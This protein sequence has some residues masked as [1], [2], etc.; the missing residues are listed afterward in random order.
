MAYNAGNLKNV[1]NFT[2]EQC[3]QQ[4]PRTLLAAAAASSSGGGGSGAQCS[5]AD[6]LPLLPP[7]RLAPPAA[8]LPRP[9]RR[10]ITDFKQQ[11]DQYDEDKSGTVE[12]V[13]APG[14]AAIRGAPPCPPARPPASQP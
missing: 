4:S 6:P 5:P 10:R 2:K 9:L 7:P 13:P 3:V 11:F 1:Y 8:P 14:A 12:C